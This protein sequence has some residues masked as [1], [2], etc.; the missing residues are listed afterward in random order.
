MCGWESTTER[1]CASPSPRSVRSSPSRCTSSPTPRSSATSA[2]PSSAASPS[3]RRC[4][5][6][7][8]PSSSSSPTARRA[9]SG[10]SSAP[11]TGGGAPSRAVAVARLAH[12]AV[13]PP[14]CWEPVGWVR[15]GTRRDRD[16]RRALPAHQ[17]ARSAG[18]AAHARG[19]RLP[20]RA[21]GH[22]DAARRRARVERGEPRPRAVPHLR[23]RLRHRRIC[24][25]H[26]R[27]AMGSGRGVRAPSGARRPSRGRRAPTRRVP[28]SP[29]SGARAP[30]S[31]SAPPRSEGR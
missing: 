22:A 29:D 14:G 15:S 18:A 13:L 24:P 31:S 12:P 11:A 6:P 20:P 27:R 25:R 17:R 8:T 19:H 21:S 5:S 2:R 4:C 28:R 16:E 7:A 23:A 9:R 1:S 30:R 3:R 26:R 10:G